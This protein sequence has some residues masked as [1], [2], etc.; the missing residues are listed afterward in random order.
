MF[1]LLLVYFFSVLA[2]HYTRISNLCWQHIVTLAD[3]GLASPPR[4]IFLFIIQ[5]P[6]PVRMNIGYLEAHATNINV[7]APAVAR[8]RRRTVNSDVSW[9]EFFLQIVIKSNMSTHVNAYLATNHVICQK[10]K[11]L[12]NIINTYLDVKV[13]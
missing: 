4:A 11:E 6:C 2:T 3:S 10:R 8:G 12:Q 7:I 9:L 5:L 13:Y 1:L